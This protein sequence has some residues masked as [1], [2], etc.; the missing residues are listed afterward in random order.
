MTRTTVMAGLVPANPTNTSAT[1]D[2]R[3]KPGHDVSRYV[4]G[5]AVGKYPS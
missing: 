3:D 1:T 4:S 2:G 5:H